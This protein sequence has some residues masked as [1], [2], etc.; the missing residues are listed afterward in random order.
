MLERSKG[1]IEKYEDLV[2][3][4]REFGVDFILPLGRGTYNINREKEKKMMSKSPSKKQL[5]PL[6]NSGFFT[7]LEKAPIQYKVLCKKLSSKKEKHIKESTIRHS[8]LV[9]NISGF[10]PALDQS[11]FTELQ[12]TSFSFEPMK[13]RQMRKSIDALPGMKRYRRDMIHGDDTFSKLTSGL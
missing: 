4:I 7:S 1:M 5:S 9:S 10:A 8:L 12:E 11:R 2:Q 6:Y 3:K 13:R